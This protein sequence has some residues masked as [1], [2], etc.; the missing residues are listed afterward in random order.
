M[1]DAYQP[2]RDLVRKALLD[3]EGDWNAAE[4]LCRR[5]LAEDPVLQEQ[6]AQICLE[7]VIRNVITGE[8]RRQQQQDADRLREAREAMDHD[9]EI[10]QTV[11]EFLEGLQGK[12]EGDTPANP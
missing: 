8:G 2:V 4:Q 10:K 7:W 12:D 1:T 5:R 9:R 3:C 11:D 6:I